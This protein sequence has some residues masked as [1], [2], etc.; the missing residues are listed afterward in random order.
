MYNIFKK[1]LFSLDAE[2]AHN[3]SLGG[4]RA[5][6]KLGV[7]PDGSGALPQNPITIAGLTFPNRIGLAAGL[8][9]NAQCVDAFAR[10]GF[11]HVEVG[12][13][14]P[15]PQPGNDIPRLFRLV[16]DRAI[17][18]RMGFNNEGIEMAV[19]RLKN[20][21]TRIPVGV[22][23]GKNKLTPNEQALEDY[24][25][26]LQKAYGVADY[27]TVN[28]SSPNTPG[29]RDLQGGGELGNL[30]EAVMN[31]RVKFLDAGI[32]SKPIF[33]KIA[34]DLS[35]D[36][37]K[38]IADT[39][40]HYGIDALIA[41]NTTISREGISASKQEIEKLGA[42]GLSG[43]P[44]TIRS[45]D[46]LSLLAGHVQGRLPLISVGGIMD[47]EEAKR[48]LDMGAALVQ[49]YTGFVYAGPGFPKKLVRATSV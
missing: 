23:I 11:G 49:V 38:A 18:N 32:S 29:L 14:T 30:L 36:Q 16:K 26:C 22:N 28:I 10:L 5:V 48:R 12:T 9:K 3:I 20:R 17:I 44:L 2:T 15:R 33:L 1:I 47:A 35:D 46:V 25:I 37:L 45:R 7:L 27:I 21:K 31:E 6:E 24:R 19:E 8:D 34:P 13:L 42:G 41:T 39:C 43:A 40:I 4:L